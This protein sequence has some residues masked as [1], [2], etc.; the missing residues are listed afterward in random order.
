MFSSRSL[1][2]IFWSLMLAP[3]V[4]TIWAR[5]S[6]PPFSSENRRRRSEAEPGFVAWN[7]GPQ[8]VPLGLR[9]TSEQHGERNH[10]ATMPDGVVMELSLLS[11]PSHP[12]RDRTLPTRENV[13]FG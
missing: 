7:R 9:G 3:A 10:H 2:P 11:S 4:Q 12:F 5:R 13:E 8:G 1:W 6:L